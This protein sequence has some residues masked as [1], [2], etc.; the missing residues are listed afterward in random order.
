MRFINLTLLVALMG[1]MYFREAAAFA[2]LAARS[3]AITERSG[4]MNSK[5][6]R[7][8]C[9]PPSVLTPT[10]V[11]FGEMN[12]DADTDGLKNAPII[13]A[14]ILLLAVWL[15]SIPPDFRRAR[16]CSD[17]QIIDNPGSRCT[18]FSEWSSGIAQY[19][20]NGGGL[21]FDFSVEKEGNVWVGGDNIE[22]GAPKK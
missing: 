12:P 20:Q 8:I 7:M 14:S 1:S 17:Q 15:F 11:L 22:Y 13:F 21:T 16:F 6:Y 10:T 4:R 9:T 5:P 18:T 2:P 19:Y 3:V